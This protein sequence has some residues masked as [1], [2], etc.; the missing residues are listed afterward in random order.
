MCA[1]MCCGMYGTVYHTVKLGHVS[2][3]ECFRKCDHACIQYHGDHAQSGICRCT[4]L[5]STHQ[6][7]GSIVCG[8]HIVESLGVHSVAHHGN[9]VQGIRLIALLCDWQC[10]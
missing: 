5:L 7:V 4:S 3:V 2:N 6:K 1:V 10:G 8:Q 9:F